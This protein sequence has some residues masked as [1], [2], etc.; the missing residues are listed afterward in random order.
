MHSR[1]ASTAGKKKKKVKTR[2]EKGG[3]LIG[4]SPMKSEGLDTQKFVCVSAGL[5]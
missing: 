3:E 1:E 2:A 4:K 5:W